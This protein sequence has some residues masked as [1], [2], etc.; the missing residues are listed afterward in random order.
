MRL[1]AAPAFQAPA[2]CVPAG[3]DRPSP[4]V[5]A[6]RFT[7]GS[8]Q[9]VAT[10]AVFPPRA[11]SQGL[12]AAQRRLTGE[13]GAEE[14]ETSSLT[15]G[16]PEPRPWRLTETIKP[17]Q[18]TALAVWVDGSPAAGGLMGRVRQARNSIEGAELAPVMVTF[19]ATSARAP[20]GPGERE[21]TRALLRDFID[22]QTAL[23]AEVERAAR[24]AVPD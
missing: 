23:P 13:I 21:R 11:T 24:T 5:A 6:Q 10:L 7:C 1:A 15:A 16:R 20:A 19:S 22:A 3:E 4:G 12:Q 8:V 18:A 14:T 9:V 17:E 2:G